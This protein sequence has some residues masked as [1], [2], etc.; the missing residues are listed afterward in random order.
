MSTIRIEHITK[1]FGDNVIIRDFCAEFEDGKFI[2]F[3]GASGCGKTTMLRMLAGFEKPDSGEIHIGDRLVSGE[4]VF[5]PP[6]KRGIGM[7]F[8]SYAVWPHLNVFDNVAYPLKLMKIPNDEIRKRVMET[9][10][11]VHIAEYAKRMP[12]ELSGGQQQR[13]ALGRA[14]AAEP[15]LLLLDEPL[16]NLDAKLREEMR[17]EIKEIHKR[18]KITVVY[19]THDQSEAMTMSDVIYVINEGAIEQAGSPV[20]IYGNPKQGFVSEFLGRINLL[21]GEA[22]DGKLKLCDTESSMECDARF[23]GKTMVAI[24]PDDIYAISEDGRFVQICSK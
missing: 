6:E 23:S 3:L 9:L 1:K 4:G 11:I 16:S 17:Y 19:V 18:L 8:Q 24:R 2:T 14:L 5:V 13:V 21:S 7:V 15:N 20:E 10:D 22:C 12:S